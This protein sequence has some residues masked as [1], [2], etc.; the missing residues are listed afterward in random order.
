MQECIRAVLSCMCMLFILYFLSVHPP[1]H[2]SLSQSVYLS[3]SPPT[4]LCNFSLFLSLQ[5]SVSLY[6]HL[7]GTRHNNL[8]NFYEFTSS[9]IFLISH[10][11]NPKVI[12]YV[13]LPTS[14]EYL[15]NQTKFFFSLLSALVRTLKSC[16]VRGG[17]MKVVMLLLAYLRGWKSICL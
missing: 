1:T 6:L 16:V 14:M 12:I 5:L 7:L 3:I 13:M 9:Y 8:S 2:L 17:Q 10:L 11:W 15:N 4:Y